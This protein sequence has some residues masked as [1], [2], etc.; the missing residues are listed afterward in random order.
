MTLATAML[1]ACAAWASDN[2][3]PVDALA[4]LDASG[5]IIEDLRASFLANL[6]Q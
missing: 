2:A 3:V 1:L 4:E 5:Y 6:S